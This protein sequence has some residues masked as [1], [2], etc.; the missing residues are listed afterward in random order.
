MIEGWGGT[1]TV[2]A[3]GLEETLEVVER[4]SGVCTCRKRPINILDGSLNAVGQA[5]AA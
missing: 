5:I 3:F 2:P 4:L 1:I